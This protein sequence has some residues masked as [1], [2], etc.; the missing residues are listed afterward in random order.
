MN[1]Y[2]VNRINR[3]MIRKK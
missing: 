3:R 1:L 2:Y